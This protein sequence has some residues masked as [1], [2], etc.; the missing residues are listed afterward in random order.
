MHLDYLL[1]T[2]LILR[3]ISNIS[4][5]VFE[6]DITENLDIEFVNSEF[7][8]RTQFEN[9]KAVKVEINDKLRDVRLKKILFKTI[10]HEFAHIFAEKKF[11]YSGHGDNYI[12]ACRILG[13]PF[14]DKIY[15][16]EDENKILKGDM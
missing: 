5:V 4:K 15:L 11:G 3:N 1:E 14:Y 7:L 9:G 16:T 6:K 10:L 2:S 8:A 13:V 12:H